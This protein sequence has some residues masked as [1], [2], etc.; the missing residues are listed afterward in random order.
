MT[1]LTKKG[2]D[3]QDFK[4]I[5]RVIQNGAYRKDEIKNNFKIILYYE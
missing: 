4:I 2:Q 1:F 3:F 5:S